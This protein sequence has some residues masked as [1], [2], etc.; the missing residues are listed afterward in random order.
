[1]DN[2]LRLVS[3]V[4]ENKPLWAKNASARMKELDIKYLDLLGVF[5]VKTAGSV[6][7]YLKGR[8]QPKIESLPKLAAK[9]NLTM[10]ELFADE[11]TSKTI[12][13]VDNSESYLTKALTIVVR[14]STCSNE[15]IRTFF[16][17]YENMGATNI[18]Q[19]S[20]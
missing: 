15:D 13:F 4:N 14:S 8:T 18:I 19:A 1:M 5:E 17:V 16:S 6:G 9:L 20:L 7:H 3:E 11:S 2:V 12:K 10:D